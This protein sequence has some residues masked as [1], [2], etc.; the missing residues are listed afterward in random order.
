EGLDGGV[1]L[2]IH[3]ARTATRGADALQGVDDN[4][5]AVRVLLN[6]H[7]QVCGA[8]VASSPLRLEVQAVEA[9]GVEQKPVYLFRQA[10]LNAPVVVL[11]REIE[12][13]TDGGNLAEDD[14]S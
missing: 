1:V 6:P 2:G 13:S 9:S 3:R 12:R 8:F 4:E 10:P 14:L 7:S 5:A 11:E